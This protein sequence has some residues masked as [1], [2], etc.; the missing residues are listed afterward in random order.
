MERNQ[1]NAPHVWTAEHGRRYADTKHVSVKETPEAWGHSYSVEVYGTGGITDMT[2]AE[3][4]QL[5]NAINT[6]L[7]T[8]DNQ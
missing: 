1:V 4:Q 6:L 5:A 2:R 3:A 7:N 8:G